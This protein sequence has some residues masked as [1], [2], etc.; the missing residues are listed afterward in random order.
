M[1]HDNTEKARYE[2]MLRED[3]YQAKKL[4]RSLLSTSQ[5]HSRIL[6]VDTVFQPMMEVGGDI[7]DIFQFNE[8]FFRVFLADA[9]GHGIQAALTTIIIKA[10]Y[11]KIKTMNL[12]PDSLLNILND[13]FFRNYYNLSVFFTALIIDI[14]LQKD[15]IIFAS[16]G[17]PGQIILRAKGAEVFGETGKMIGLVQDLKCTRKKLNFNPSDTLLLFTD[18]IFEAFNAKGEEL[19]ED[20]FLTMTNKLPQNL[21]AQETNERIITLVNN[22]LWLESFQDDVTLIALKSKK[23]NLAEAID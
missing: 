17:H 2:K 10:E 4:Q 5:S 15:E 23:T 9:T 1:F 18:G 8:R 12:S 19:G 11:E 7:Y 3:L 22:W 16:A 21:S 6:D 13:S 14:D 20:G